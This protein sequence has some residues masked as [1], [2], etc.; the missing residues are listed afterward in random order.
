MSKIQFDRQ[1]WTGRSHDRQPRFCVLY[2]GPRPGVGA[3]RAYYT[4]HGED[5][6]GGVEVTFTILESEDGLD[7]GQGSQ[8][9]ANSGAGYYVDSVAAVSIND[10]RYIRLGFLV[11]HSDG[12]DDHVRFD[13]VSGHIV[14]I[15]ETID[16]TP[17]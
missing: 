2:E 7:W 13:R 12:S 1:V 9:N 17:A 6:Q 14:L 8:G 5:P 11:G 15:P 16:V 3:A 10:N 4:L